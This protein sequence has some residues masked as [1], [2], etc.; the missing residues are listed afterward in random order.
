M[1]EL[2]RLLWPKLGTGWYIQ[3]LLRTSSIVTG[4]KS[5]RMLR[6]LACRSAQDRWTAPAYS[7]RRHPYRLGKCSDFVGQQISDDNLILFKFAIFNLFLTYDVPLD[8]YIY[9]FFFVCSKRYR[10]SPSP[11]RVEPLETV[12]PTLDSPRAK[13]SSLGMILA[14]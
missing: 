11:S 12:Q 7:P 5:T 13:F 8:R 2:D 10:K 1:A 3:P 14:S 6:E 4:S 9:S